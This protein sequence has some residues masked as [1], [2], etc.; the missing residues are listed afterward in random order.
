MCILSLFIRSSLHRHLL[1][2]HLFA[3]LNNIAM[4]MYVEILFKPLLFIH[5]GIYLEAGLLKGIGILCLNFEEPPHS[6]TA[7]S[8]SYLSPNRLQGSDFSKPLPT[9]VECLFMC[10]MVICITSVE[11][12]LFK[13]FTHFVFRWNLL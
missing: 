3:T 10:L 4:N 6:S 5:L 7:T 1:C 13:S 12:C 9:L 8:P 2:L 11:K